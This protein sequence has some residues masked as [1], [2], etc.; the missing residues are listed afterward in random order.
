MR[1]WDDNAKNFWDGQQRENKESFLV[2]FVEEK[3][4][5]NLSDWEFHN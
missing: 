3:F 4:F 1:G 5:W 2:Y